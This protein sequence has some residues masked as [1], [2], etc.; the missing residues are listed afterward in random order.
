MIIIYMCTMNCTYSAMGQLKI[1]KF[2][3]YIY[4]LVSFSQS[5]RLYKIIFNLMI[6]TQIKLMQCLRSP[7]QQCFLPETH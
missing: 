3:K 4:I 1:I 7:S 5:I 6:S 2:D